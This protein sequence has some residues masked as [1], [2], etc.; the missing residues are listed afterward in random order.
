M[1]LERE[2]EREQEEQKQPATPEPSSSGGM[3]TFML[4]ANDDA[5]GESAVDSVP[6]A[7]DADGSDDA[8]A[9]DEHGGAWHG[10]AAAAPR[11]D[12]IN[13]GAPWVEARTLL[14]KARTSRSC[15]ECGR[16]YCPECKSE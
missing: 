12:C 11:P 4:C 13:C 15:R 1:A 2:R 9:D 5:P 14:F 3:F 7:A 6:P 10:A 16:T 8:N